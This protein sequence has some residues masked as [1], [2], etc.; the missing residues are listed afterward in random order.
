M[1]SFTPIFL[2]CTEEEIVS[3]E[4]ERE[5]DSKR[6][7]RATR[8]R[9]G[10]TLPDREP[11]KTHRS[12]LN[13]MGP[14]GLLPTPVVETAP[15]VVA[16]A[17]TS[18]RAAAIAAQANINLMSQDLP[19]PTPP[20][21]VP[22]PVTARG[23]K[24]HHGRGGRG[25]SR[26]S[27]TPG[28]E[29]S[30]VNPDTPLT[31]MKRSMREESVSE[32]ASPVPRKRHNN[33]RI[34]S[35]PVVEE[36]KPPVSAADDVDDMIKTEPSKSSGGWHCKKCGVPEHLSGGVRKDS[37]GNKTMCAT[38]CEWTRPRAGTRT[39]PVTTW[40]TRCSAARYL[41]RYGKERTV[42]YNEDE[43]FHRLR[44]EN[45]KRNKADGGVQSIFSEDQPSI[46]GSTS[47]DKGSPSV[48]SL[49]PK[50]E[51]GNDQDKS[52][53]G[54]GS[55]SGSGSDSS[56]ESS[57]DDDDDAAPRR[58]KK[59]AA[60]QQQQPQK[61]AITP[62]PKTPGS[63]TV[64]MKSPAVNA[65]PSTLAKK[66]VDVSWERIP[67][68]NT[69]H[70]SRRIPNTEITTREMNEP[71]GASAN[72]CAGARMDLEGRSR[73]Q[74]KVLEGRLCLCAK[75]Q[76]GGRSPRLED[77]VSRL[78]RGASLVRLASRYSL[79]LRPRPASASGF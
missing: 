13:Q 61:K 25:T 68:N 20:S 56:S 70:N 28:R 17:T 77:E 58:K 66:G 11:V 43:E 49:A 33:G 52:E 7:K 12:L 63:Q 9:R 78:V 21:P 76:A 41:T 3:I 14:N 2:T 30:V 69:N 64:G 40:L 62:A 74:G 72:D 57:S 34:E 32:T 39:R 4:K 22:V 35:P 48:G 53:S 47:P 42:K 19:I 10:I 65:S 73:T 45:G 38:C 51:D 5:R 60:R 18:R 6:K 46:S 79:F 54:S 59:Q 24:S 29:G 26:M 50:P 55:G 36:V 16:A 8:A 67:S 44:L 71:N 1:A 75:A 37:S 31:G 15:T 27:P 23:R